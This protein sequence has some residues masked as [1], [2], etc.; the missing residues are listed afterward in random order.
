MLSLILRHLL[1]Y[2][3]RSL[4]RSTSKPSILPRRPLT[5]LGS[6]SLV[7]WAGFAISFHPFEIDIE[8]VMLLAPG[9][10]RAVQ[11]RSNLLSAAHR[12]PIWPARLDRRSAMPGKKGK[13]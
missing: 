2:E 13:E 12:E 7:A 10:G 9:R 6:K 11:S 4:M 8:S 5:T 1:I 3:L